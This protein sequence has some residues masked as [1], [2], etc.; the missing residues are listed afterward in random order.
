MRAVIPAHDDEGAGPCLVLLHSGVCDRR[1]WEAQAAALKASHRVIR[2]DLRGFGETPLPSERFS[3]ADDVIELLDHLEVDRAT[4]VG[5]SLGGR[6]AL[7][8]AVT[9]PARV[10]SLVLLCPAFGGLDATPRLESFAAAEERLLNRG[11]VEAAVDLNVA[12]WLG[13]EASTDVRALVQEMQRHAFD[14]QLAA[15]SHAPGP[16]EIPVDVD[17]G[18]VSAPTHIVSGGLDLDHFQN[19]A[20]HLAR[21]IPTAH[22][23][24]L[25]WAAHLPS[26]ERPDAIN[27]L[28]A[29]F[30]ATVET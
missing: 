8:V 21:T 27:D 25:E 14:V 7:E 2:P 29:G 4:F 28:L 11:E 15:E 22:L 16:E 18:Q 6:V 20:R 3:F 23:T 26:L 17:P 24:W 5:S 10:A 9:H 30:L 13:P 12:T 19:V 1:M